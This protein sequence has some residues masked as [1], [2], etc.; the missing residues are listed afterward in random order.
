MPA[1][2]GSV[3]V[4]ADFHSDGVWGPGGTWMSADE[5]P[6]SQE[7][8]S[9]L[10][11]WCARF[12]RSEI[13]LDPGERTGSFDLVGFAADGLVIAREVKAELPDWTVCYHDEAAHEAA[14]EGAPRGDWQFEVRAGPMPGR[15]A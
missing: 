14:P 5:L 10:E 8:R 11:A 6:I 3:L 15:A 1:A 4:M 13:H 2:Q 9:R 7:L 12:E